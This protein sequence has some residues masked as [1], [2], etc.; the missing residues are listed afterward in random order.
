MVGLGDLA[1][2]SFYSF[3]NGASS[4]GSV[5]VGNGTS[6]SGGEAFIWDSVNGMR[7][8]Q[9]VLTSNYG[10]D[11]TGWTL[12]S[13]RGISADGMTIVG[14]GT[15]NGNTEAWRANLTAVP[16][17]SSCALLAVGLAGL[18]ARRRRG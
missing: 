17:P 3:A 10:L 7:N 6:D 14:Y 13:A 11:L 15:H 8:L 4:D 9:S 16:E 5:V 12:T 1:G 18:M 2:G